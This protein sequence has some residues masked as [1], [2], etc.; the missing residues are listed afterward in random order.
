MI[1]GNADCVR[2]GR[3]VGRY[4]TA[5]PR[6]PMYYVLMIQYTVYVV[7]VYVYCMHAA[8]TYVRVGSEWYFFHRIRSE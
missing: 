3:S 7:C 4:G 2:Y 5:A 8:G 6:R 1:H